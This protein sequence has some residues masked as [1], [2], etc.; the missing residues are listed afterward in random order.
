MLVSV[1]RPL[2]MS[3]RANGRRIEFAY[4]MHPQAVRESLRRCRSHSS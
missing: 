3:I 4:L 2:A 1:D